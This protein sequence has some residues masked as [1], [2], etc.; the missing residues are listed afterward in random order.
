MG[1][2]IQ[3]NEGINGQIG[4]VSSI[5]KQWSKLPLWGGS[6]QSP[7]SSIK[8][9]Y[10]SASSHSNSKES[11]LWQSTQSSPNSNIPREQ[12][13]Q[14]TTT[15]TTSSTSSIASSSNTSLWEN[16]ISK[17]SQAT[18]MY[19]KDSS[20]G[21]IW[22][23]SNDNNTS[24]ISATSS[25]KFSNLWGDSSTVPYNSN[26]NN[27]NNNSNIF[28]KQSIDTNQGIAGLRLIRPQDISNDV[29]SSS[30]TA[31]STTNVGVGVN[32]NKTK[33]PVGSLWANPTPNYNKYASNN[34]NNNMVQQK[35]PPIKR[36]SSMTSSTIQQ[37]ST[38][39]NAASSCL[40]LF[41]DEFLN[42]LNMIN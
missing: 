17:M 26:N 5:N 41:S 19:D 32:N 42:Y 29:W 11:L 38:T 28:G 16:P 4:G 39:T 25:V 9:Q 40:Q 37:P 27:T 7:T 20:Y 30:S 15:A 1:N 2:N 33:E 34:N 14:I 18:L 31:T 35:I 13:Q 8:T 12:L 22:T 10:H 3:N 24:P 23:S 21:S 6:P 36:N